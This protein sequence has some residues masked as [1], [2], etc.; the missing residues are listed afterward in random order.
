MPHSDKEKALSQTSEMCLLL[1]HDYSRIYDRENEKM[2]I[3][4][5][6]PRAAFMRRRAKILILI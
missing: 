2:L 6:L 5:L 1:A 3:N 4:P